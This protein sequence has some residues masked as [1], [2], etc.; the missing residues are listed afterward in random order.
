MS[1]V[2]VICMVLYRSIFHTA[3]GVWCCR[4]NGRKNL[5]VDTVSFILVS[6]NGKVLMS[7]SSVCVTAA[8]CFHDRV[9]LR[10]LI[11]VSISLLCRSDW[12]ITV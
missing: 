7:S 5:L 10:S 2:V 6:S 8:L 9:Q 12:N 4:P 3:S 11:Y 1:W